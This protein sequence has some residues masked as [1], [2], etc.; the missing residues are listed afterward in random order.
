MIRAACVALSVIF[1]SGSASGQDRK[2]YSAGEMQALLGKGLVVTS[3]DMEGGK[4]FTARITLAANGQLSG[5][6]TPAGDKAIAVSGVWKLKGAQ[7]CR[8]L[9]PLQPEEICEVW[10]KTGPKE[11]IIQVDGKD[12]SVNRWQ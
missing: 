1:I 11:A 3:S 9:A 5:A 8:T 12:A 4:T 2:P 6:L 7:V 10:I